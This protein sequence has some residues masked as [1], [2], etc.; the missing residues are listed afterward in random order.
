VQKSKE[1][2]FQLTENIHGVIYAIVDLYMH[3]ETPGTLP[4]AAMKHVAEF[5]EYV[6]FAQI[7]M[8]IKYSPEPCIKSIPLWRRNWTAAGSN[9]SSARVK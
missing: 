5:T 1:Q 7:N 3:M 6:Y 4:P 2:C 9:T 8:L